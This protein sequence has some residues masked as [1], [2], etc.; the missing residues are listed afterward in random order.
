MRKFLTISFT[1][2]LL[3]AVSTFTIAHQAQEEF[4]NYIEKSNQLYV[5]KGLKLTL[6]DYQKSFLTST[7]IMEID[8]IN[9][10]TAK[11]LEKEYILPLKIHYNIEH[12]PIFFK[13]GFGLGLSKMRSNIEMSKLLQ[14]KIKENFLKLVKEDVIIKTEMVLSFSKKLEYTIKSN[15]IYVNYDRKNLTISPLIFTGVSNLQNFKGEGQFFISDMELKEENSSN[16]IHLTDILV[17][18]KIHELIEKNILIGDFKFSVAN[19]N[20][21]ENKNTIKNINIA[22]NGVMSSQRESETTM[23]NGFM[24]DIDFKDTKLPNTLKELQ[25][26]HIAMKMKDLGI[27][28]VSELQKVVQTAQEEQSKLLE[29][30]KTTPSQKMQ[31]LFSNFNEIQEKMLTHIIHSLNNLLIKDKTSILYT[32]NIDTKEGALSKA[33]LEVGYT[34]EI[35]FKGTIEALREKIEA[36]IL[37]LIR[38]NVNVELNKKHLTLLP[39]PMLELQ[40]QMGVSQG[41]IKEN[42]TSYRL[43]GYYKDKELIIN[44]NNLTSTVLPFLMMLTSQ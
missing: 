1:I 39:L 43:N 34:G 5:S 35:E 15:E 6:I 41:F 31:S 40:L 9:P 24:V 14:P 22:L 21:K 38:L 16:S 7:A 8:L 17:D 12:G 19:L 44:D 30:L 4:Q 13:N 27:K 32:V 10:T 20:I 28:G 25:T 23:N 37:S 11:E 26:I 29:Q 2:L 33:E 3:W 42:N 18:M 36:Q